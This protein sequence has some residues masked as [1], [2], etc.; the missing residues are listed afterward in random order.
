ILLIIQEDKISISSKSP[1]AQVIAGAIVAFQYNKDTR[2]RNGSDPLDSMVIPAIT[3]FGT[4]PVF[5]KV[6]VTE[7]L[8]KV[9]AMG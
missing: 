1:E 2:D 8:N 7:Q 5:Y 9:V 6:H 4:H 3:V